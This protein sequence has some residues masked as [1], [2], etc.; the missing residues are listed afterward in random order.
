MKGSENFSS[1]FIKK[2]T[3]PDGLCTRA[4]ST[5]VEAGPT[6]EKSGGAD[7]PLLLSKKG[8][9]EVEP[10]GH[11][12]LWIAIMIFAFVGIAG[13]A[14]GFRRYRVYRSQQTVRVRQFLTVPEE[15][16]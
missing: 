8:N 13:M 5:A 10:S 4:R 12:V 2:S 7:R 9:P 15:L 14:E 3:V 6:E 11:T 1:S 16:L